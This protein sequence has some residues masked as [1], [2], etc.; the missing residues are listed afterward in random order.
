MSSCASSFADGELGDGIAVTLSGLMNLSFFARLVD[1]LGV[2][3]GCFASI[4]WQDV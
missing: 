4:D 3:A 1:R 2:S